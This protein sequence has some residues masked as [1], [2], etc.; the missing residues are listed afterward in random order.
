MLRISLYS[1]IFLL[2]T[3]PLLAAG[4]TVQDEY[5]KEEIEVRKFDEEKWKA[6]SVDIDYSGDAEEE[7]EPDPSEGN[8]KEKEPPTGPAGLGEVF[9]FVVIGGA[10]LLAIFL[11]VK[12]LGSGGPKNR[13]IDLVSEMEL[14]EI[15]ENLEEAELEDPIRRAI[16]SG[17]FM[18]ATRLYY[19]A[20]L[21][22]LAANQRIKWKR[23]KTNG[24]YLR[25]LAGSPFSD[26][27]R[28]VTLIFER[29]WYGKVELTPGDFSQIETHFKNAIAG[30]E[31]LATKP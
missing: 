6:L 11:L 23:D 2:L 8:K 22:E 16:A 28:D 3:L 10:I 13:K 9:K 29:V 15:E 30:A 19:L 18:L 27:F 4:Q 7:K 25:E 17:D 12:I 21:K 31:R 5:L 24:E 26:S 20:L 1:T 14:E